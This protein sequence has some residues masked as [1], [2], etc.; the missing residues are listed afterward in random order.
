[1]RKLAGKTVTVF[2]FRVPVPC[3]FY[4]NLVPPVLPGPDK[5]LSPSSSKR[6]QQNPHYRIDSVYGYE[7]GSTNSM[8]RFSNT[9]G[10]NRLEA[11][12]NWETDGPP[13]MA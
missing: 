9:S 6:S 13:F 5:S 7:Y 10:L 4:R 12:T 2:V 3:L 8:M 11:S 1:M